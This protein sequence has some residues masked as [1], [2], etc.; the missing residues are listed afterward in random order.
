[1]TPHIT[2]IIR[3]LNYHLRNVGRIRRYIDQETCN[4]AIR[5]LIISRLD[6]SNSILNGITAKDMRKLQTVQNRAAKLIF[7]SDRRDHATP[8]LAELHWL[9]VKERI[10]Y[11]TLM[12]VYK[13]LKDLAP[14]YLKDLLSTNDSPM[15]STVLRSHSD[16]TR[17]ICNRTQTKFGDKAFA[18]YGPQIWNTLPKML[19]ES[20]NINIFKSKLKTYLF[21]KS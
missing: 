13:C 12:L 8:L 11:K 18:N 17:L 14:Q 20:S 5:A 10:S 21:P 15:Y 16:H 7:K 4:N 19:R 9:P 1:M 6:Y 3:S 2:S